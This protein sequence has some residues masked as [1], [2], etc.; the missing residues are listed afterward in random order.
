[1]RI[2]STPSC[3]YPS[4]CATIRSMPR[5]LSPAATSS[6]S[7]RA[8]S[9]TTSALRR[10]LRTACPPAR[11][12]SLSASVSETEDARQAGSRPADER[13][14]DG[15]ERGDRHRSPVDVDLIPAADEPR[16]LGRH[17]R[18][19]GLQRQPGERQREQRAAERQDDG[20]HEQLSNHAAAAGSERDAQRDALLACR[21]ADQQQVG[22][23]AQ[24]MSR[25]R[26]PTPATP[27]GT[28]RR[29]CPGRISRASSRSRSTRD[30]SAGARAPAGGDRGKRCLQVAGLAAGRK[31]RQDHQEAA[32]A[33]GRRLRAEAERRPDL[34]PTGK[35]NRCGATPTTV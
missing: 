12:P 25:R 24:A 14:P 29:R 33:I 35:S 23:F 30:W 19:Q 28:A 2:V 16:D 22:T 17:R 5:T 8:T 11:P 20:F 27:S 31:P 15:Q 7:A 21:A 18:G 1:M 32:G 26:S 3:S 6:V 13:R 10:R 34:A 9:A 4:S